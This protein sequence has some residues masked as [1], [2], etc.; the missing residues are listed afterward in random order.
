MKRAFREEQAAAPGVG[1]GE[2]DRRFH[3]LAAGTGEVSLFQAAGG[4]SAKAAGQLARK[5]GHVALEHHR[6][7]SVQ[8]V[9]QRRNNGRV[10]VPGIVN[11]V[12]R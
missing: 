9:L 12:T 4:A 11:A 1:P 2:F 5:F 8:F 3:A 7:S 10:V 6:P